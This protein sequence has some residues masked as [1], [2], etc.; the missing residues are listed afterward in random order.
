MISTGDL[1]FFCQ[2]SIDYMIEAI[3]RLDD[4]TVNQRPEFAGANTPA[5]L[6]TH[7]L[8]AAHFWT[9]EVICGHSTGRVRDDEF[10]ATASIA[11]LTTAAELAKQRLADLAP[12]LDA[13]VELAM[14]PTTSRPFPTTWT[15]GL[16][17]M[18]V[19]EEL[20]QHL[21]HLEVTVDLLAQTEA[22]GR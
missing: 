4:T 18:H 14:E 7:A 5:Q 13:A 1:V 11:E 21:G 19:Y 12:E 20:A 16:A 2:R 9:A 15:V 8:G 17:K 22:E 6:I 10:S 3:G